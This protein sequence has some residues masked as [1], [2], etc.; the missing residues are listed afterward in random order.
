LYRKEKELR[1]FGFGN[2]GINQAVFA[3][4]LASLEDEQ[5]VQKYK[6]LVKEGQEY[7]Y[8]QFDSM[9]LK[10]IPTTTPFYEFLK[11]KDKRIDSFVN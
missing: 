4:G 6:N 3:G 7:F 9:G 1:R 2:I 11:R 8:H 5:H 10:Y